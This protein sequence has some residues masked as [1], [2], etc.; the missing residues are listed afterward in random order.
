MLPRNSMFDVIPLD[1]NTPSEAAAIA[2]STSQATMVR[3]GWVALIRA[4]RSVN[5]DPLP[6]RTLE[7]RCSV[8]FI[9]HPTLGLLNGHSLT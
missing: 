8:C 3:H 7:A 4:S 6:A 5:D 9:G 1:S 2:V